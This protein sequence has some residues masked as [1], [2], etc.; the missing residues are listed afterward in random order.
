MSKEL[1]V[2]K[3]LDSISFVFEIS[4]TSSVTSSIEST[5]VSVVSTSSIASISSVGFKLFFSDF[6][7]SFSFFR[8]DFWILSEEFSIA[9]LS[10]SFNIVITTSVASS[11]SMMRV[12]TSVVT[13]VSITSVVFTYIFFG[14]FITLLLISNRFNLF[15]KEFRVSTSMDIRFVVIKISITSS[16]TSSVVST[17]VSVVFTSSIA[18]VSVLVELLF[19]YFLFFFFFFMSNLWIFGEEFSITQL[20]EVLTVSSKISV[21]SSVTSSIDSVVE[22]VVSTSSVASVVSVLVELFLSD[23]LIIIFRS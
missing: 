16:V 12:V 8:N 13:A 7:L 4:V 6:L 2:A 15:S 9:Q 23:F 21:A 20:R 1:V 18:S 17:I 3:R 19:S 22:S 11:I 14:D 5:I 10:I